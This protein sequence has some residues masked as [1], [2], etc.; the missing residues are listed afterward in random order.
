VTAI[1]ALIAD[2]QTGNTYWDYVEENIFNRCGTTGSACH[3]R[4]A[5]RQS[6][7]PTHTWRT[8]PHPTLCRAATDNRRIGYI[9]ETILTCGQVPR[10]QGSR[11]GM[12]D[13]TQ[14]PRM[15]Q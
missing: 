1:P 2:V 8:P 10:S 6:T 3:G 9:E 14:H 5:R 11:G 13:P 7:L 15:Q 12:A 4:V